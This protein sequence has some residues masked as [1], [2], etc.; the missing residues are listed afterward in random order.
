VTLLGHVRLAV[1][2]APSLGGVEHTSATAHVTE[3]TLTGTVGTS[4]RNT[5]DTR[6]GTTG[7]PG[8]SGGVVTSLVLDGDGLTT[9]LVHVG[10]NDANDIGTEGGL[11]N[12]GK[13]E[14]GLLGGAIGLVD[15]NG[16]TS[17]RHL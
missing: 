1:P 10:V 17:L 15:R 11:E 12:L 5:G 8:G 2:P 16:R 4:T 14:A 7:T 13:A 6:D 9:V 3:S